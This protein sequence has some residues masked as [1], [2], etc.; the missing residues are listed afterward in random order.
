M[1]NILALQYGD[2][3]STSLIPC[4]TNLVDV[5]IVSSLSSAFWLMIKYTF[6]N[7]ATVHIQQHTRCFSLLFFF[8]FLK[9]MHI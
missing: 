3:L 4:I 6:L 1:W 2:N 9:F 5:S 8:C 7:Q